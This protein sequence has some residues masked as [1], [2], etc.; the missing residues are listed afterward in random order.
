MIIAPNRLFLN[1]ISEALPEL[2]VER[3]KQTTFED[4]AA[5]VIGEK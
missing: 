1:Y 4:F 2:G 3:V 5:E